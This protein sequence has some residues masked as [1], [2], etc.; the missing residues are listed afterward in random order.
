MYRKLD[1]NRSDSRLSA[2]QGPDGDPVSEAETECTCHCGQ[3][4]STEGEE[5]PTADRA[6]VRLANHFD[7]NG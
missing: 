4:D 2:A 1:E 7:I 5:S 3:E 6:A